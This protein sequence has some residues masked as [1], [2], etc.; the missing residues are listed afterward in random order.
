MIAETAV[1]PNHPTAI[2]YWSRASQKDGTQTSAEKR[3][4]NQ[5]QIR[6][7][8]QVALADFSLRLRASA[9]NYCLKE[10][11]KKGHLRGQVA[12]KYGRYWTRTNDL[13]DVN[14]AL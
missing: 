11:I 6:R 4:L 8:A 5:V 12:L 9:L 10:P 2:L 14:V 7:L 3:G 13:Y 1:S